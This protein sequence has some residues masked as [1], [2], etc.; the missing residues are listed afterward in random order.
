M[1]ASFKTI[2]FKRKLNQNEID[3]ILRLQQSIDGIVNG[4]EDP[5]TE[6]FQTI[7]NIRLEKDLVVF[8]SKD[9]A[10]KYIMDNSKK[11]KFGI[12]VYYN[13]KNKEDLNKYDEY[14]DFDRTL[15]GAWV[16]C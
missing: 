16:A 3:T 14:E 12:A 7:E 5:Y 4:S 6:D 1:G 11:W 8:K 9:E 15:I 13:D 10:E 2:E